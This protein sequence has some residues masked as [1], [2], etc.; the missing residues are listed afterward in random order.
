MGTFIKSLRKLHQ[1]LKRKVKSIDKS[2]VKSY[3]AVFPD[4]ANKIFS[5][6]ELRYRNKP[7]QGKERKITKNGSTKQKK[8]IKVVIK[9]PINGKSSTINQ[10]KDRQKPG[11]PNKSKERHSKIARKCPKK[12]K[13]E[14]KIWILDQKK[15]LNQVNKSKVS[16]GRLFRNSSRKKTSMVQENSGNESEIDIEN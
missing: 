16:A 5:S 15:K 4:D 1:G 3:M 8:T 6:K 11:E 14:K 12:A 9:R 7:K 13:D 2:V 10:S